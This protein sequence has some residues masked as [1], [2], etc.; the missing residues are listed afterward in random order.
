MADVTRHFA[1]QLMNVLDRY[2]VGTIEREF[3]FILE[4]S[5]K[6]S[7]IGSFDGGKCTGGNWLPPRRQAGFGG[8]GALRLAS[9]STI[10]AHERDL[11]GGRHAFEGRVQTNHS[12]P[13]SHSPS[14][15]HDLTLPCNGLTLSR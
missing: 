11:L 14:I 9:A 12:V 7:S 2:P 6:C 8:E 13:G 1:Q 5:G 3:R 4:L 15:H 10:F